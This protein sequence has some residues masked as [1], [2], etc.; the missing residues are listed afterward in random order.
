DDRDGRQALRMHSP[1]SNS[2]LS[3][4]S[5]SPDSDSAG[6]HIATEGEQR[7]MI[8][9]ESLSVTGGTV[10]TLVLGSQSSLQVGPSTRVDL[11]SS[12]QCMLDYGVHW[13]AGPVY[14]VGTAQWRQQAPSAA[15]LADDTVRI[16][17]GLREAE[18][19]EVA[20]LRALVH[21]AVLFNAAVRAAAAAAATGL[22]SKLN[23]QDG[24]TLESAAIG[25]GDSLWGSVSSLIACHVAFAAT[26]RMLDI[27][28]RAHLARL[29]LD[30]TS[31]TLEQRDADEAAGSRLELDAAGA[32][33]AAASPPDAEP[34][35]LSVDD[36]GVLLRSGQAGLRLSANPACVQLGVEGRAGMRADAQQT[37]LEVGADTVAR[38]LADDSALLSAKALRIRAKR[39]SL[40]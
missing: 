18:A 28:R 40:L 8:V 20:E 36:H 21:R 9:G 35:C 14:E 29:Q 17:A 34:T 19:A 31:L 25:A 26:E 16:C 15:M 10:D 7:S 22:V 30:S 13:N 5:S 11:L 12:A 24:A 27:G 38:L 33:L 37:S 2:S 23:E 4:G 39:S 6:V 3:L 1:S 32:R